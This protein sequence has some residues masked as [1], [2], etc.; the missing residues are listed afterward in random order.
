MMKMIKEKYP[1]AEHWQFGDS[2]ELQDAL[3]GLVTKE[4]KTATSCSFASYRQSGNSIVIGNEYIVLNS[5]NEP[6]CV[7]RVMALHL[8]RFSEMTTELAWKEGE[9]D[10]S[11]KHWQQEHQR[12]FERE[13]TFSPEMEVVVIEFKMIDT[14]TA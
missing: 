3:A 4:I 11:V 10:R 7:V 14:V 9:G 12:F 5:R 1:T 8:V 2:A 13:G 6:T